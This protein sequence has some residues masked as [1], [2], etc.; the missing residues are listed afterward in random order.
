MRKTS[1]KR[2]FD[3]CTGCTRC[4]F[5]LHVPIRFR[6]A[7]RTEIRSFVNG[8]TSRTSASRER[9]HRRLSGRFH[10]RFTVPLFRLHWFRTHCG[11]IS[12]EMIVVFVRHLRLEPYSRIVCVYFG[13]ITG[14]SVGCTAVFGR[15]IKPSAN[16]LPFVL[17]VLEKDTFRTWSVFCS[18]IN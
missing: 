17:C 9:V 12:A 6:P 3:R 2:S 15:N 5:D 10:D 13:N 11:T 16:G 14:Q 7:D 1:S 8:C 4:T 18:L